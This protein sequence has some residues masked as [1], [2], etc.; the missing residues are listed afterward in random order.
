MKKPLRFTSFALIFLLLFNMTA[1]AAVSSVHSASNASGDTRILVCT[2]R[3]YQWITISELG[4][5][6]DES[7]SS[8]VALHD[9][10]FCSGQFAD[11]ADV[12]SQQLSYWVGVCAQ[13]V[14][15]LYTDITHYS[16]LTIYPHAPPRAPPIL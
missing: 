10:P 7:Q 9:C 12:V 15:S 13:S 14:A 11:F 4:V 8:H 5:E 16:S 3:G 1:A 2:S 6:A